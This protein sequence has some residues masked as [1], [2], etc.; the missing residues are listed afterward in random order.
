MPPHPDGFD[1]A[2]RAAKDALVQPAHYG[3]RQRSGW[4]LGAALLPVT[5]L[6]SPPAGLGEAG[7]RTTG[8]AALRA[9]FRMTEA[10]PLPVTA[11]LPLVLFPMLHV[12]DVREA[13]VPFANPLIFL[14]LGGFIIALA[15]QRWNL[16]RRLAINLVAAVGAAPRRIVAGFL[17]AAALVSLW[18][19]N[20]A[21]PLMMRPIALSGVLPAWP[22]Q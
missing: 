12:S 10:I 14:F 6:T 21:I 15:M 8:G 4:V 9:V 17:L 16:H 5:C 7:W 13:A 22:H 3:L 18:M 20:P 19:S 2:A 1:A 11:L